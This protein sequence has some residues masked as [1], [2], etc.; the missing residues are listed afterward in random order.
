MKV[1]GRLFAIILPHTLV[2]LPDM[3]F[4]INAKAEGRVLIP[5]EHRVYPN[6]TVQA[7]LGGP[8]KP[9]CG[10]NSGKPGN[11]HV[12]PKALLTASS[13]RRMCSQASTPTTSKP[14]APH[15]P[16]TYP[17]PSKQSLPI[18]TSAIPRTRFTHKD[19]FFGL[20]EHNGAVPCVWSC[21]GQRVFGRSD[22][23]SLLLWED[24]MV[25]DMEGMIFLPSPC[26]PRLIFS[27]H[28]LCTQTMPGVGSIMGG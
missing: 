13:Q 27:S 16:T 5:W 15:Q 22:S 26:D 9:D 28:G 19:T 3:E 21:K 17:L 10:T 20:A 18:S 7:M 23:K 1:R 8:F 12:T 6:L 25:Q 14:T 2:Q 11:G 24:A 4:P